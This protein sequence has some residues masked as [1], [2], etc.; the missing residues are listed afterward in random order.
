VWGGSRTGIIVYDTRFLSSFFRNYTYPYA[1]NAKSWTAM[2]RQF[3]L[4]HLS[5][6]L[7]LALGLLYSIINGLYGDSLITILYLTDLIIVMISKRVCMCT[8]SW[9]LQFRFII[10]V[11]HLKLQSYNLYTIQQAASNWNFL[12]YKNV[13]V[14]LI[15][16][17]LVS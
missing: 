7:C 14:N 1:M 15:T 11:L 6:S 2:A 17:T 3:L 9:F 16:S 12:L 8:I 5:A 4:V 10:Q 13:S